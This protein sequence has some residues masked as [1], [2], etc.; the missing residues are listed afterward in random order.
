MTPSP[1]PDEWPSS[2][3]DLP[4]GWWDMPST[5]MAEELERALPADITVSRADTTNE[6]PVGPSPAF[7]SLSGTFAAD[8]GPGAFQILL[9]A[10]GTS[11]AARIK[12]R[13]YMKSCER[14]LDADGEHIG[15][16]STDTERGTTYYDLSLL[17]PDGG[18]I[19][20]YVGN[21]TGEKPGYEAPS[22]DVPPLSRG[23]LRTL[24]EDPVWTSYRP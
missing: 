3:A 23:Q 2:E 22:A 1:G 16:L 13:P 8:T 6:G 4:T 12:C 15:R 17:G 9:Y 20:M 5:R 10:P 24:A 21:S 14:I 19:Y 11:H 7:G 18:A